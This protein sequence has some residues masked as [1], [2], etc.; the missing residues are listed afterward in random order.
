MRRAG[1]SSIL[2]VVLLLAV[3]VIVEAQQ[4]PKLARIGHLAATASSNNLERYEA[5][6]QGL[7]T[8]GYIEGQTIAIEWRSADGKF[9]RLPALAAELVRLKVDVIVSGGSTATLALKKA[10]S[11]IPIIMSQDNDPVGNGFVARDRKSTRLNSS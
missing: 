5:F 2:F 6:R 11:T 1:V 9:D 10:T 3:A 7:R 8:L 4:R